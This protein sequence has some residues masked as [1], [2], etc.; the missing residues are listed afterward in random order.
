MQGIRRHEQE[1][2][3]APIDGRERPRVRPGGRRD[4][5]ALQDPAHG[6]EEGRSAFDDELEAQEEAGGGAG[7]RL[8]E[9]ADGMGMPEDRLELRG[10]LV[11]ESVKPDS[12]DKVGL[13]HVDV[14]A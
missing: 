5:P 12:Q 4:Q 14:R 10:Q 13:D 3:V 1:R 8:Q 9:T 7:H 6:D 11:K 2:R